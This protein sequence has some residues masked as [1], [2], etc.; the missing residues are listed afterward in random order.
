MVQPRPIR[1]HVPRPALSILAIVPLLLCLVALLLATPAAAQPETV[2]RTVGTVTFV[3]QPTIANPAEA[4]IDRAADTIGSA[5]D[6]FRL[7][8]PAPDQPQTIVIGLADPA[9]FDSVA[10]Q[11]AAD[12]A[13]DIVA[14][15]ANATLFVNLVPLANRTDAVQVTQWR[16][17]L[18]TLAIAH[19]TGSQPVGIGA[20]LARYVAVAPPGVVSRHVSIVEIARQDGTLLTWNNLHG[21]EPA[22]TPETAAARDAQSFAVAAFLVDRYGILQVQDFLARLANAATWRDAAS[23]AFGRPVADIEAQWLDSLPSWLAAGWR[24]NL[25]AAFDLAPA[26]DL[27]DRGNFAAARTRLES[28]QRLFDDLGDPDRVATVATLLALADH[29]IQAESLMAQ[30]QTALAAFDY[31]RAASL[32]DQAETQFAALPPDLQPSDTVAAYRDLATRGSHAIALL[33]EAN[34]RSDRWTDYLATRRAARDAGRTFA[35]L[36]DATRAEQA[37]DLIT[38]ID[39]RQRRALLL[40]AAVAILGALW[41]LLWVRSRHPESPHWEAAHP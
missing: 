38:R 5:A 35:S 39:L 25:V 34:S 8:F 17:A 7:L 33:K 31:D 11:L 4:F 12:P 9:G 10:K 19:I 26:R 6:E 40:V 37:D 27:L 3:V 22:S 20:G 1:P 41:L 21:P 24:A 16:H 28:S 29:G 14:D 15:P 30:V 23:E 13:D 36:G 2:N 18:A 32:L